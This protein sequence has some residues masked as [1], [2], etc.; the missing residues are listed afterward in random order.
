MG[1]Y[2]CVIFQPTIGMNVLVFR[3]GYLLWSLLLYN[4]CR[5]GF[6]SLLPLESAVVSYSGLLV[7]LNFLFPRRGFLLLPFFFNINLCGP[8]LLGFLVCCSTT[9]V[10][11]TLSNRSVFKST[12]LGAW[13]SGKIILKRLSYS[14]FIDKSPLPMLSSFRGKR[15]SFNHVFSRTVMS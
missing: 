7:L 13:W 12:W 15:G 14:E 8:T 2:F 9:S 6:K 5:G 11:I 1:D 4:R 10:K 3:S